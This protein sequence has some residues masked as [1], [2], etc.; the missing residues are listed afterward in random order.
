LSERRVGDAAT[1]GYRPTQ[2]VAV[3][4][5]DEEVVRRWGTAL[6]SPGQITPV[7]ARDRRLVYMS[8]SHLLGRFFAASQAKL[9]EIAE[10]LDVR[11]VV[12]LARC[13]A[14]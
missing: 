14:R 1:G 11:Y 12:N 8:A 10:R 13:P 6:P 5:S 2:T 3:G 7:T 9:Q 4:W